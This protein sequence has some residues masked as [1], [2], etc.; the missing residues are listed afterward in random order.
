MSTKKLYYSHREEIEEYEME[1]PDDWLNRDDAVSHCL[2]N[3]LIDADMLLG[4]VQEI[5]DFVITRDAKDLIKLKELF[6][7]FDWDKCIRDKADKEAV[8][9]L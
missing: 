9:K 4:S 7:D 6:K 8:E 1:M 3:G 2:E 5:F